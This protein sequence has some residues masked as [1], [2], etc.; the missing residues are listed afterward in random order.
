VTLIVEDDGVGFDMSA[1]S[2][3]DTVGYGLFG[4]NERARLLHGEVQI[5]SVPGWGTRIRAALPYR[6]ERE[7]GAGSREPRPET[8][9]AGAA[10]ALAAGDAPFSPLDMERLTALIAERNSRS[11][12]NDRES[13]VLQLLAK[14]ARNKE[15]AASSLSPSA[16]SRSTSPASSAN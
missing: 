14:G 9:E 6:Q 3:S 5:E 15:I 1:R 10:Q 13:E 7:Q 12:I 16:P 11:G 4:M 8:T 2:V